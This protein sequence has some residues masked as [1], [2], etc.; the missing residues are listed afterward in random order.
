MRGIYAQNILEPI[1]EYILADDVILHLHHTR[2]AVYMDP[3]YTCTYTAPPDTLC[4]RVLYGRQK[5]AHDVVIIESI[6]D[7]T[8][9]G[10]IAAQPRGATNYTFPLF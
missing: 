5:C 2:A 10:C 7:A 6:R 1:S 8:G 3:V 9:W 4:A